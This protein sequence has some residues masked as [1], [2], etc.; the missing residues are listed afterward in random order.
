MERT[1]LKIPKFIKQID[2]VMYTV[3]ELFLNGN[4]FDQIA[5]IRYR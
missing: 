1:V 3:E 4:Y 5:L 2:Y